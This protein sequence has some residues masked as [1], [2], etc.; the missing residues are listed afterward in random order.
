MLAVGPQPE[1]GVQAGLGK[2]LPQFQGAGT[3][4]AGCKELGLSTP[5]HLEP[6]AL[7]PP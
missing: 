4:W 2:P 5:A 1:C 6:V 7:L 3:Q